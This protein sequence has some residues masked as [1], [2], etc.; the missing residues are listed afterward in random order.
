MELDHRQADPSVSEP[1]CDHCREQIERQPHLASL[2]KEECLFGTKV[3]EYDPNS[4]LS[5]D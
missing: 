1:C 4:P 2:I 3:T 5:W